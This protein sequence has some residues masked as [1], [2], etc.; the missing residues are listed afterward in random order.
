MLWNLTV[1]ASKAGKLEGPLLPEPGE[2][3]DSLDI[4]YLSPVSPGAIELFKGD[5]VEISG[6]ITSY[7]A[8]GHGGLYRKILLHATSVKRIGTAPV[9]VDIEKHINAVGDNKTPARTEN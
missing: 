8:R 6:Y 3:F 2:P 7:V 4:G 1:L 5:I 9:T